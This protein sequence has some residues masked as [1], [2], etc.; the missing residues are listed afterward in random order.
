MG[1][2]MYNLK[3]IALERQRKTRKIKRMYQSGIEPPYR[4]AIMKSDFYLTREWKKLRWETLHASD[5]K[6]AMCGASKQTGAVM[7]VDH[8]YPRSKYPHLELTPSNL[9]VLC[10]DCNL[11]KGSKSWDSNKG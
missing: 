3:S 4:P 7:H 1:A 5:G 11:G 6:C 9:Q 8:K 2:E 10:A